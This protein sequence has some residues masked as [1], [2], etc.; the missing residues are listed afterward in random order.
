MWPNNVSLWRPHTLIN[1]GF[2]IPSAA[3]SDVD[4]A[5]NSIW[6]VLYHCIS[7]KYLISICHIFLVD[8]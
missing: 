6:S 2:V 5:D 7:V 4:I 8:F 3:L 1:N